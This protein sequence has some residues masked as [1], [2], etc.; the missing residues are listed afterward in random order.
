MVLMTSVLEYDALSCHPVENTTH[1]PPPSPSP[2][3]IS[4]HSQLSDFEGLA[5]AE[6]SDEG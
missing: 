2:G 6:K 5:S 1:S 3:P 4:S